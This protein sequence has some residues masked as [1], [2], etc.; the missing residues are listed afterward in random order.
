MQK[1][2]SCVKDTFLGLNVDRNVFTAQK[3]IG[4]FCEAHNSRLCPVRQNLLG[5]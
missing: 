4:Q 3:R 5:L 2:V 1:R